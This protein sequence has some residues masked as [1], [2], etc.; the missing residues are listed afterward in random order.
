MSYP[1][2]YLVLFNIAKKANI[3]NLL[4]TANA[5]AVSEVLVVGKRNFHE[6]G[7]FG[8][9]RTLRKRH[10]YSLDDGCR[11]LRER[12]CLILGVEITETATP[13]TETPFR[14]DTAF[15]V[16]NEGEGLTEQQ[17]A[18]CDG[19][20]YVP[21]YGTAASLNVNVATAIVLHHFAVWAGF[22]ESQRSGSKF[23]PAGSGPVRGG[24]QGGG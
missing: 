22:P 2:S 18:R 19:F 5:F 11:H 6:F 13:V 4:R 24:E 3:G 15:M 9:S 17:L 20:I 14:Q 23:L 21:Q 10:F 1:R 16:G 8:T 7:A 12:N